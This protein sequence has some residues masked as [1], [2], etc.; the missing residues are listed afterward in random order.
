MKKGKGLKETEKRGRQNNIDLDR[1]Q[2]DRLLMM[3]LG[4]NRDRIVTKN[5]ISINTS[6]FYNIFV[7]CLFLWENQME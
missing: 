3:T 7:K 4:I 1:K 2:V 5:K 6:F